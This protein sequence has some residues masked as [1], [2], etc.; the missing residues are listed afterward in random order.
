M[1]R[2]SA[3][4]VYLKLNQK[5]VLITL[6]THGKPSLNMKKKIWSNHPISRNILLQNSLGRNPPNFWVGN[7][8]NRWLHKFILTLSDLYHA[9]LW[10]SLLHCHVPEWKPN[11]IYFWAV[12]KSH[13]F[14]SLLELGHS[15]FAVQVSNYNS[16]NNTIYSLLLNPIL[17]IFHVVKKII[18]FFSFL[19]TTIMAPN[20][21]FKILR[22]QTKTLWKIR[23]GI[24][25]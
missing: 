21:V 11:V 4:K 12:N 2:I 22:V 7:L 24:H 10:F 18:C 17:G 1:W 16:L 6:S 25:I 9:L 13:K 14:E 19:P 15:I 5:L 23:K 8:E 20:L 3:L